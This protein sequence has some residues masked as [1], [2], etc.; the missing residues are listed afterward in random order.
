MSGEIPEEKTGAVNKEIVHVPEV[1][2]RIGKPTDSTVNRVV[3]YISDKFSQGTPEE[4]AEKQK[5]NGLKKG[6]VREIGEMVQT[7]SNIYV[8]FIKTL[9]RTGASSDIWEQL[10]KYLEKGIDQEKKVRYSVPPNIEHR[11]FVFIQSLFE[12]AHS[13]ELPKIFLRILLESDE[14]QLALL[15]KWQDQHEN[16]AEKIWDLHKWVLQVRSRNSEHFRRLMNFPI[17]DLAPTYDRLVIYLEYLTQ[18]RTFNYKEAQ[19][20]IEVHLHRQGPYR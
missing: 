14:Q 16:D 10:K 1:E 13:A 9:E 17:T 11:H 8:L 7:D 15:A 4:Q 12:N 2:I 6:I 3:R 19:N 20:Y 18:T 5:I